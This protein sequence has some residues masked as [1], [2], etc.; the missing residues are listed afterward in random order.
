MDGQPGYPPECPQCRRK[1]RLCH[2]RYADQLRAFYKDSSTARCVYDQQ[3]ALLHQEIAKLIVE[4][5][6]GQAGQSVADEVETLLKGKSLEEKWR[7][8]EQM[9]HLC[10]FARFKCH[11]ERGYSLTTTNKKP[12]EVK[13]TSKSTIAALLAHH[14]AVQTALLSSSR[15]FLSPECLQDALAQWRRLDLLR[16]CLTMQSLRP[17]SLTTK[18][19]HQLLKNAHLLLDNVRDWSGRRQSDAYAILKSAA[20]L[21][22][23]D[24]VRPEDDSSFFQRVT[25]SLDDWIRCVDCQTL[26]PIARPCS[27]PECLLQHL[28]L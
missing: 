9:R 2:G 26:R 8:Y 24:L 22:E 20:A 15:Q 28:A 13:L 10:L 27:S 3:V 23:F 21:M 16:Q 7:I 25:M 12:A 4:N 18:T 5:A 19:C 11:L 6:P 1:V 17:L 14:Q